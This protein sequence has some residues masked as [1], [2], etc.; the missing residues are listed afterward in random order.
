MNLDA[1]HELQ[2]HFIQDTTYIKACQRLNL[3]S[4][5]GNGYDK[6]YKSILSLLVFKFGID[7]T[8]TDKYGSYGSDF[9]PKQYQT[10]KNSL[11]RFELNMVKVKQTVCR[12][13]F[14]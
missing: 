7:V 6:D 12:G 13:V 5:I 4:S 2:S 10:L 1:A 14:C 9:I 11:Q 8:I 3:V